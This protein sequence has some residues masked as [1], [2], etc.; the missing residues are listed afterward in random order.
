MKR[1]LLVLMALVAFGSL[2]FATDY[3]AKSSN[4]QTADN[5]GVLCGKRGIVY[6]VNVSSGGQVASQMTLFNSSWTQTGASKLGPINGQTVG[7]Y[8]YKVMFSSGLIYCSSGTAAMQILY[9]CQ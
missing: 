8:P 9:D 2:A 1:F 7:S 3:I 4:T 5:L 6:G